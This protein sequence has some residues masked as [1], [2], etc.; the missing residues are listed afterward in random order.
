MAAISLDVNAVRLRLAP[1]ADA[2]E[3]AAV[4]GPRSTTVGGDPEALDGFLAALDADEVNF[5]RLPV[6][7]AGHSKQIEPLREHLLEVLAPV[8]GRTTQV[9]PFY[10]TVTGGRLAAKELDSDYWWRNARHPVLLE[11]AVRALLADGHRTFLEVNP[12]PLLHAALVETFEDADV[13]AVALSTL[14]RDEPPR[15]RVLRATADAFQAG[16]PVDWPAVNDGGRLVPPAYAFQ[17]RRYWPA[18]APAPASTPTAPAPFATSTVPLPH[19]DGWLLTAR[20]SPA[21]SPWLNDHALSGVPLVPGAALAE[22][23]WTAAQQAGVPRVEELVLTEPMLLA[24]DGGALDV[25]VFVERADASG[26]RAVS[27][28]ARPEDSQ[29]V[30]TRHAHG[31]IGGAQTQTSISMMGGEWPPQDASETG[32]SSAYDRLAADGYTYGPAFHALRRLWRRGEELPRKSA[33]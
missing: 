32:L 27:V 3:V 29:E 1:W 20:I 26:L 14:R 5:R 11:P 2:L 24:S 28:H 23:V 9:V 16:L 13:A 7:N 18:P 21:Q 8:S 30:W 15:D 12:H 22:L 17:R 10:S 4:N 19:V 31:R 25:Q 6:S 33:Y